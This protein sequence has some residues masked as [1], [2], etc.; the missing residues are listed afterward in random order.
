MAEFISFLTGRALK[1]ATAVWEAGDVALLSYEAFIDRFT[2]VFDH[3]PE[4]KEV[5][6][7]LLEIG[8]RSP[9][10]QARTR[11]FPPQVT[12]LCYSY[13]LHFAIRIQIHVSRKLVVFTGLMD[14]GAEGSFISHET[15]NTNHL[16]TESLKPPLT[17]PI[18]VKPLSG[19]LV[20]RRRVAR[21]TAP[22]HL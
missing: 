10:S 7:A 22:L 19:M 8:N 2:M 9:D 1:W 4:G 15:V 17:P 16:P 5:S 14:S 18:P 12:S 11:N 20:G 13:S 21:Q 6:D 3:N